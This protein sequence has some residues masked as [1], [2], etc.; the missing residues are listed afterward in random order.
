MK[1][2]EVIRTEETS[3]ATYDTVMEFGKKVG[4][5]CVTCR[6]T[7]G[8]IVNRL[9]GPYISEA[10]KMLE[11]ST[12]RFVSARFTNSFDHSAVTPRRETSTLP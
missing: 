12:L 3:Q 6:D 10:I 4:K 1:L 2:L 7:P 8:F 5:T 11:V 9:L